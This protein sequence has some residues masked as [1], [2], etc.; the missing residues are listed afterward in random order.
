[1][2][3][4]QPSALLLL[5]G[6]SGFSILRSHILVSSNLTLS[7]AQTV[8]SRLGISEQSSSSPGHVCRHSV[9]LGRLFYPLWIGFWSSGQHWN[10]I[11]VGEAGRWNMLAT[12]SARYRSQVGSESQP[13]SVFCIFTVL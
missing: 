8:L 1:M 7:K 5:P 2:A 4:Q 6:Y 12:L 9:F 11:L 3:P 10:D 13:I